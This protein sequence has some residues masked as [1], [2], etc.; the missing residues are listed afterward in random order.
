MDSTLNVPAPERH[1]GPKPQRPHPVVVAAAVSLTVFSLLGIG[2]ITGLVPTAHSEKAG[3]S[4]ALSRALP[5]RE[6]APGSEEDAPVPSASA[7]RSDIRAAVAASSRG[8]AAPREEARPAAPAHSSPPATCARCGVVQAVREVQREGKASGLGAVAG[9]V[10]GAVVGN[11]FGRGNGNAAMTL[12]GAAGGAFA[13]NSIEKNMHK[14]TSYRIT[15][16]MDD[17]SYRTI[18][19][20]YVPAVQSGDRVKVTNGSVAAIP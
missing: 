6:A 2:A 13:G 16:R 15:V 1:D 4:P 14:E 19:Q 18:A 10:A 17:G 12:L 7:D 20:N 11:Q 8:T 3:D 5:D 9:G